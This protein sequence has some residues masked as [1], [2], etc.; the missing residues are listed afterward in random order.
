MN[1][2][3]TA[4]YVGDLIANIPG[5]ELAT[6][7]VQ[8][9]EIEDQIVSKLHVHRIPHLGRRIDPRNDFRAWL[10]LRRLIR[11]LKPDVVHT[12]TFKAGLIGRLISGNHKRVHTFHGHLFEDQSFSRLK[13]LAITLIERYLAKRTDQLISVGERVGKELRER[14]IGRHQTWISVPPGVKPLSLV[15][16]ELARKTYGIGSPEILV[17]W[18]ARVTS[19]KNPRLFLQ[20]AKAL[21]D[22]HFVMAGGGDLF[23]TIA[24]EASSNIK[25]LGWANSQEF[26]AAVDIAVSTSDN[27]GMPIALIEA[28]MGG[29]PVVATNVGSTSEVIGD[30]ETGFITTNSVEDISNAIQALINDERLRKD[31]SAAAIIQSRAKFNF[32]AFIDR[33]KELY[34]TIS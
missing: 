22:V 15:T 7:F 1:V 3:G 33:H 14:G 20:V 2:G 24:K 25:I 8:G 12:H 21:P 23:E 31:F 5:N 10:E 17:G 18:M 16:K 27:E 30:R 32:D 19:V 34:K 26:W 29:I 13:Q 6:G 4:R 9:L 11:E 28:Q